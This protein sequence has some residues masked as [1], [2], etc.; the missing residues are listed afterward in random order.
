MRGNKNYETLDTKKDGVR[1][2][3]R[4]LSKL[5]AEHTELKKSYQQLQNNVVSEIMK[6]AGKYNRVRT[7]IQG[8]STV[9]DGFK[10]LQI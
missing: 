2:T 9:L 6:V 3:S 7:K 10:N 4:S 8:I 5:N 1:F